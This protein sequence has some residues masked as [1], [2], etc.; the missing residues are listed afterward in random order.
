MFAHP[1]WTEENAKSCTQTQVY[2]KE[3]I[4]CVDSK[5]HTIFLPLGSLFMPLSCSVRRCSAKSDENPFARRWD[6]H[7]PDLVGNRSI[8]FMKVHMKI[9][10]LVLDL[11]WS[12]P[13]SC[14]SNSLLDC[15]SGGV[16]VFAVV[17]VPNAFD[18]SSNVALKMELDLTG[19]CQF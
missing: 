15:T 4:K 9:R 1:R 6:K 13:W 8:P 17:S 3:D 14:S 18:S 2:T 11:F 10:A 16:D 19:I 12:H 7:R 5:L